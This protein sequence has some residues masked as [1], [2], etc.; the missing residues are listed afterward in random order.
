MVT[1]ICSIGKASQR[2]SSP[3]GHANI[4]YIAKLRAPRLFKRTERGLIEADANDSDQNNQSELFY[5]L[6]IF[7]NGTH[8]NHLFYSTNDSVIEIPHNDKVVISNSD[9]LYRRGFINRGVL[10]RNIRTINVHGS[11]EISYDSYL[12]NEDFGEIT[13]NVFS[14][15]EFVR[16]RRNDMK[17]EVIKKVTGNAGTSE[18]MVLKKISNNING[19]SIK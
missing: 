4:Q 15:G 10:P 3:I 8:H 11:L 12:Y 2:E 18:K 13:I 19:Y 1:S 16:Q 17:Y 7:Q 5:V 9:N 6:G 14:G